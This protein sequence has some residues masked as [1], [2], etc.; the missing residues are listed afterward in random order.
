VATIVIVLATHTATAGLYALQYR[1]FYAHWHASFP[2][3]I[4]F[5]QLAFTSAGAIYIYT[6]NSLTFYWPFS[7]A[8]FI[9]FGLWFARMQKPH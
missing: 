8:C 2:S 4:W 9:G 3:L 7:L 1:M 6:V 5:F